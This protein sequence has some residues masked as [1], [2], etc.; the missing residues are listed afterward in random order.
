MYM[1]IPLVASLD[2]CLPQDP[3]QALNTH[4]LHTNCATS[5]RYGMR[6]KHDLMIDYSNPRFSV[7]F[8]FMECLQVFSIIICFFDLHSPPV[9]LN[10]NIFSNPRR[11]ENT[12][13]QS[14]HE[15]SFQV[16]YPIDP[17][18][19]RGFFFRGK[20][21]EW[22]NNFKNR[23]WKFFFDVQNKMLIFQ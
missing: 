9:P 1:Y 6:K 10:W 2:D 5:T 15:N 18:A 21:R 13:L 7:S 11:L 4:A 16:E 17:I 14:V 23:S 19:S 20:G 22:G 8:D 12:V 3:P